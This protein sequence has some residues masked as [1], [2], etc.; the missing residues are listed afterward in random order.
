MHTNDITKE[1]EE[2]RTEE[3]V[4]DTI[5]VTAQVAAQSRPLIAS[6]VQKP[7]PPGKTDSGY[8]CVRGE[9]EYTCELR[10]YEYGCELREY[11]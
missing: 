10:E 6:G 7:G 5:A 4:S 8:C 2:V 11:G 3:W 1:R 9:Y